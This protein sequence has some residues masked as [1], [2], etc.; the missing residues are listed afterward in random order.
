M[1]WKTHLSMNKYF[2]SGRSNEKL[3]GAEIRLNRNKY[4]KSKNKKT[5]SCVLNNCNTRE[6]KRWD[7]FD[8]TNKEKPPTQSQQEEQI[9]L[10]TKEYTLHTNTKLSSK[11]FI[12]L[13][14]VQGEEDLAV[15]QVELLRCLHSRSLGIANVSNIPRLKDHTFFYI[16]T[17][18]HADNNQLNPKQKKHKRFIKQPNFTEK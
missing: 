1:F 2:K 11:E 9:V 10:D 13:F 4:Q 7:I 5:E 8:N 17:D 3:K 6:V 16:Q 15:I 12:F 14:L 18:P